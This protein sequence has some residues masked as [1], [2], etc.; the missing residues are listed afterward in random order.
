[1][2]PPALPDNEKNRLAELKTYAILDSE[3]EE[4]YNAITNLAC[5]IFNM[6]I[7]IISLMDS[8]RQWFKSK[9]GIESNETTRE[10]SFCG[11][12]ILHPEKTLIVENALEDNRFHDNPLVTGDT[13]I[14][15]YA[16]A[17]IVTKEGYVL[18]TLCI[19]DKVPRKL[20]AEQCKQLETLALQVMNLMELRKSNAQLRIV[21]SEKSVLL[22]EVHH[23]VKNNLQLM[24]S[25]ISLQIS[26]VEDPELHEA[27]SNCFH[28]IMAISHIHQN[29]HHESAAEFVNFKT[30]LMDLLKSFDVAFANEH[31][32]EQL[33][34]VT[35]RIDIAI[36]LGLITS[37]ILTNAY[38]HAFH[39]GQLKTIS[40]TFKEDQDGVLRLTVQDNGKGFNVAEKW[41]KSESLGF[42]IIKTLQHQIN[43]AITC[44]SNNMGTYFAIHVHQNQQK[45]RN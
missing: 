15:F 28:R 29:L 5:Q 17:P 32:Y 36:P 10:M 26:Q 27:F 12:T 21:N 22:K 25:L 30:Y 34:D 38:K 35:V 44:E 42:E 19:L 9:V 8:E 37:E 4:Q 24:T 18:G 1:M 40:I 43:A 7:A 13:N 23:R 11:H 20:S 3:K 6:P 39:E 41:Q 14:R 33:Q 45:I 31:N 16:G 2:I